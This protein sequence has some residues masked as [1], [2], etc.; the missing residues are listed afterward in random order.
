M[1]ALVWMACFASACA[2]ALA[3]QNKSS[4][5]SAS[6]L[7]AADEAAIRAGSKTYEQAGNQRDWPTLLTVFTD[8][9][10][11]MPPNAPEVIGRKA[12]EA[13]LKTYP[14]FK[15]LRLEP[16]EI[17]GAGNLAYVRG[18]YSMVMTPSNQ[19]EQPD[20]GK[21]IE[22]W[23]KQ[24]DG[25][26]KYAR[27]IFNSDLP[28]QARPA[29]GSTAASAG[30]DIVGTY[31]LVSR[32]VPSGEVLH[33]PRV[34]GLFTVTPTTMNFNIVVGETSFSS[35]STYRLTGSTLVQTI[36][37]DLGVDKGKITFVQN[38]P[39]TVTVPVKVQGGRLEFKMPNVKT[40]SGEIEPPTEVYDGNSLVATKP[41][42]FVDTWEKI[43]GGRDTASPDIS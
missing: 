22:I 38:T 28:L 16:Q 36:L 24:S 18:R 42:E 12:V 30:P 15:N 2:L 21:Y 8:D 26:W 11:F 7:T 37:F 1:K 34:N 32:K 41:G 17:S 39:N 40:A 10:V 19:P 3:Q 31:K 33:P 43:E 20:A 25:K 6:A 14:A 4:A 13:M 27:G 29:A 5:M 35:F 9:I 23:R